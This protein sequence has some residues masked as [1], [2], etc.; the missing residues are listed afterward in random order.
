MPQQP[1]STGPRAAAPAWAMG[2]EPSPASLV[3]TPLA[4]P[5]WTA[6]RTVY[7]AAPPAAAWGV[8][9]QR[10]IRERASGMAAAFFTS[11]SAPVPR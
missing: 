2:A 3:K 11:T 9:A 1:C 5:K 7:P 8:K 10:K 6:W 4:T